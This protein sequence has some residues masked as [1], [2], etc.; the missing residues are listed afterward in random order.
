MFYFFYI[1]AW[2]DCGLWAASTTALPL[3][4]STIVLPT[5]PT[6]CSTR[7]IFQIRGV[8]FLFWEG[9]QDLMVRFPPM[10]LALGAVCRR[11]LAGA[12]LAGLI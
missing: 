11:E 10:F 1:V 4:L 7:L 9:N 6:W 2:N 3:C 12:V 8:G 5:I